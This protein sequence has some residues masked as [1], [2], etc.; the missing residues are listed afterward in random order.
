MFLSSLR[1]HPTCHCLSAVSGVLW[2]CSLAL[3]VPTSLG[4]TIS[5][6]GCGQEHRGGMFVHSPPRLCSQSHPFLS[7]WSLFYLFFSYYQEKLGKVN[8]G[9]LVGS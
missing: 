1:V 4:P 7:G 2:L 3:M 6:A 9:P 5:L 8:M